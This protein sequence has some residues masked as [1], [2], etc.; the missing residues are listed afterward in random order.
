MYR[1]EGRHAIVTGAARGIG[2][3]IAERLIAEGC[4]VS[5]WDVDGDEVALAANEIAG[6]A[7]K[8]HFAEVDVSDRQAVASAL[9]ATRTAWN[10]GPD[11]LVNNAGIGQVAS[12]LDSEPKDFDRTI[13]VNIGGTYNCC[14]EVAPLMRDAGGGLII[15]IASWFG[16]SGRPMSMAYCA[17]KFAIIGMTQSMALDLSSHGIRV[18]AVCPGTIT[19]TQMRE[20]ADAAGALKGVPP[21]QEREHLIPLGRLGKPRDIANVV[22]FL[23]SDEADYMTGQSVNVTGGLWMN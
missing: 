4:T 10:A 15:N 18:N 21:A 14:Y 20:Q 6:S 11:I 13:A 3:A 5:L 17:S 23:I 2:R 19:D 12:I 22:A 16:K 9:A 1:L 7:G 8:V